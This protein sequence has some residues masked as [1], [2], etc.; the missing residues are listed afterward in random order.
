MYL[1]TLWAQFFFQLHSAKNCHII[2]AFTRAEAISQGSNQVNQLEKSVFAALVIA[3]WVLSNV[4]YKSQ[5]LHNCPGLLSYSLVEQGGVVA[6]RCGA[7]WSD[8]L[9]PEIN[10]SDKQ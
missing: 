4:P 9:V 10:N 6:D 2:S 5:K 3:F 8:H 1:F 7:P